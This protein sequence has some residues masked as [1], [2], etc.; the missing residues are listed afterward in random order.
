MTYALPEFPAIPELFGRILVNG[1][2]RNSGYETKPVFSTCHR[3]D[4]PLQ[5]GTTPHVSLEI[6]NEAVD[7]A[8]QAWARGI[9][10]WPTSHMGTELKPSWLFVMAWSRREKSSAGF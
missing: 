2:L 7:A 8:S 4:K 10:S 1:E 9:G 6:L 5:I 3:G